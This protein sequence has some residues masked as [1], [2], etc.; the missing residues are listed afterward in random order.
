MVYVDVLCQEIQWMNGR[1][2][3]KNVRPSKML[4]MAV[5]VHYSI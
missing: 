4:Q 1:D 3:I 2:E 5:M